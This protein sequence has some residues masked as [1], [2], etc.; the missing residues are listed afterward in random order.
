M[1]HQHGTSN[2]IPLFNS[3]TKESQMK[4][5]QTLIVAAALILSSTA[6]AST[7]CDHRLSSAGGL[8]QNTTAQSSVFKAAPKAVAVAQTKAGVR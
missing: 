2:A 1:K 3:V 5:I 8:F 7:K 6:M 4:A